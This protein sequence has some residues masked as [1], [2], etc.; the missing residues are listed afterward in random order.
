MKEK[1]QEVFTPEQ[2][3][4]YLQVSRE[5]IYRYIRSGKLVASKLGRTYRVP[6]RS[7]ELLL[8]ET[9]TREDV[10]L[11]EYTGGE[12]ATF[13][14]SDQIDGEAY[15]NGGEEKGAE[16]GNSTDHTP[17]TNEKELSGSDF[18]LSF[19]GIFSSGETDVS[20][21]I[22]QYVAEALRKKYS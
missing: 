8:W 9:R 6:K 22:E 7:L 10:T 2:A 16:E 18:L 17:L 13:V 21:N 4:E 1:T 12:I 15:K 11:R 14:E 5:T 20:E 19:A 3:A